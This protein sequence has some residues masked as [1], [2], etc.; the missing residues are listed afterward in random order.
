LA[1]SPGNG[2]EKAAIPRR[3][4]TRKGHVLRRVT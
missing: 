4:S 3:L 1:R 2:V